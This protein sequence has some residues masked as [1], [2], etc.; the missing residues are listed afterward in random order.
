MPTKSSV[1]G[2]SAG[3]RKCARLPLWS[4]CCYS[5]QVDGRFHLCLLLTLFLVV[6]LQLYGINENTTP[7]FF[8]D[9]STKKFGTYFVR[10]GKVCSFITPDSPDALTLI[11]LELVE[12]R[13]ALLSPL[14][15]CVHHHVKLCFPR[16][17]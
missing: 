17:L 5:S 9:P 11:M 16:I 6:M 15:P 10:D 1:L 7:V 14:Q 12:G 3:M 2:C 13:R 8:G 4:Q